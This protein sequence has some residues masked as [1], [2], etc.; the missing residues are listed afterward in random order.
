MNLTGQPLTAYFEP[1]PAPMVARQ[2]AQAAAELVA[3]DLEDFFED[4]AELPDSLA[5][6]GVPVD[7][8]WSYTVIGAD[9][10]KVVLK[11]H[12]QV[13]AFESSE[14]PISDPVDPEP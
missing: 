6:I 4:F 8:E 9:R 5:E 2:R 11:R 13:V 14:R 3:A 12:G 7:G 10:F 1:T